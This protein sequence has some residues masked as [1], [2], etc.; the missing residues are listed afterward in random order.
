M[1]TIGFYS[2]KGGVGR[3]NLLLNVAWHLARRRQLHVGILDLDL[4]APGLT[5]LPALS[6][7]G[8]VPDRGLADLLAAASEALSVSE[9]RAASLE[10]PDVVDL[11]YETCMARDWHGSV[12][13]APAVAF[14]AGQRS[15]GQR[16]SPTLRLLDQT[17]RE[18]RRIGDDIF[19]SLRRRI[20]TWKAFPL[21]RPDQPPA[22]AFDVLLADMRTG[23]TELADT[24]VGSLFDEVI[25][26][27]GLNRQNLQGLFEA[28]ES[29]H[30]SLSRSRGARVRVT[31]VF[32]PVPNAELDTVR[33][34]L[35]DVWTDL[36]R[37]KEEKKGS[38]RILLDL[39]P[40]PLGGR[41]AFSL[42]HYTD[43][44][45]LND[46]VILEDYP[47]T[48]AAREITEFAE[49]LVQTVDEVA[50]QTR[51]Q[52]EQAVQGRP[53]ETSAKKAETCREETQALAEQDDAIEDLD[54]PEETGGQAWL[55]AW[56]EHPPRWTWPLELMGCSPEEIL[57]F[58]VRIHGDRSDGVGADG[59]LDALAASVSI[60]A[61]RKVEIL[62]SVSRWSDAQVAELRGT[63]AEER[64]RLAGRL[65]LNDLGERVLPALRGWYGVVAEAGGFTADPCKAVTR[66]GAVTTDLPSWA[67]LGAYLSDADT[68]ETA[69][70]ALKALLDRRD[71]P[72]DAMPALLRRAGW[73]CLDAEPRL[74]DVLMEW[75]GR[76]GDLDSDIWTRLGLSLRNDVGAW[77]ASD[78]ALRKAIV[79]DPGNEWAYIWLGYL[80]AHELG[81]PEEAIQ[82]YYSALEHGSQSGIVWN[83]LGWVLWI[84]KL[85]IAEAESAVR[86]SVELR[87]Q[88]PRSMSNLGVLLSKGL[89]QHVAAEKAFR[90]A[91]E[92][93]ANHQHAWARIGDLLLDLVR[94]DEAIDAYQRAIA[95]PG[96][97]AAH[98][99]RSLALLLSR[100][101]PSA[102]D[103][104]LAA[105]GTWLDGDQSLRNPLLLEHDH[106]FLLALCARPDRAASALRRLSRRSCLRPEH[107]TAW[108]TARLLRD[109]TLAP[110]LPEHTPGG[111]FAFEIEHAIHDASLAWPRL[112]ARSRK[113][114]HAWLADALD[115]FVPPPD[116]RPLS[117]TAI[118][119]EL[120][121]L[122]LDR[123]RKRHG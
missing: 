107:V 39:P 8:T 116:S 34:K 55:D 21:T 9:D 93:D 74:E 53:V 83:N 88:S 2:Y 111:W 51:K 4:E 18:K 103:L 58:K 87:P 61:P 63:L 102:L 12:H 66:V 13:L 113:T 19:R 47:E 64:S 77:D 52:V 50:A 96:E 85:S 23:L 29:F 28:L 78:R 91:L 105:C 67:I 119:P 84:G 27:S 16:C 14:H 76:A 109:P 57:A 65:T 80:S 33:R 56:W 68:P 36:Q 62:R 89:G 35:A 10:V 108:L 72:G 92:L 46:G 11:F 95:L 20:E 94:S 69:V 99:W 5:V 101:D 86:R 81:R 104:H 3:T 114:V 75:C 121:T 43:Y 38:T 31:P 37:W 115:R 60:E 40:D 118:G 123:R 1:R 24:A 54:A 98:A 97:M 120:V 112:D 48:L 41:P 7:A 32:S 117:D 15:E 6:P 25:L 73:R 71:V 26:V 106:A 122:K 59:I 45:A 22:C 49:R 100:R 90:A 42:V 70:A 79:R 17:W 30:A 82:T 44:L 110:D